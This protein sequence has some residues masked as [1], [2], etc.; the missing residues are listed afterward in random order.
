MPQFNPDEYVPVAERLKKF[1]ADHPTWGLESRLLHFDEKTFIVL[2]VVTN[3]EGR[4][5]ASGLAEEVRGAGMVNKTNPLENCETSAWGRALANMGYEVDRGIASREEIER[6]Q[7]QRSPSQTKKARTGAGTRSEP[8]AEAG[9]SSPS[10]PPGKADLAQRRNQL[11][12]LAKAL[13]EG[14]LAGLKEKMA[15]AKI[16]MDFTKHDEAQVKQLEDWLCPL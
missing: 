11:F 7:A 6:A 12:E 10:A 5:I 1:R 4:L 13:P 9:T 15:L 16:P 2:A 8:A 14:E 3:D